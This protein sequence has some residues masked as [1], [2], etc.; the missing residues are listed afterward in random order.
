MTNLTNPLMNKLL[1]LQIGTDKMDAPIF[2]FFLFPRR[3]ERL[4]HIAVVWPSEM[5]EFQLPS[6]Q[7]KEAQQK[8]RNTKKCW[9]V[10]V[11]DTI[12]QIRS[13]DRY[14][15]AFHPFVSHPGIIGFQG[16]FFSSF[17]ECFKAFKGFLTNYFPKGGPRTV[18]ASSQR[19]WFCTWSKSKGQTCIFSALVG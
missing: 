15:Q 9:I 5:H 13:P 10:E 6:L 19:C 11:R 16:N 1:R 3:S 12:L 18:W 17:K 4:P 14:F 2:C 8:K 7:D